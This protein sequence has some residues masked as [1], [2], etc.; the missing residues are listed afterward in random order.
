MRSDNLGRKSAVA[1]L[2][3]SIFVSIASCTKNTF[4]SQAQLAL[5]KKDFVSALDLCEKAKD[6]FPKD[7]RL[8]RCLKDAGGGIYLF[9]ANEIMKRTASY[10][11]GIQDEST[12]YDY[13]VKANRFTNAHLQESDD[14]SKAWADSFWHFTKRYWTDSEEL[15]T[16]LSREV[17]Q[18]ETET[19]DT[20]SRELQERALKLYLEYVNKQDLAFM[21]FLI[22]ERI[23]PTY[24]L[25]VCSTDRGLNCD[26]LR[27]EWETIYVPEISISSTSGPGDSDNQRINDEVVEDVVRRG[28]QSAGAIFLVGIKGVTDEEYGA[29]RRVLIEKYREYR[30]APGASAAICSSPDEPLGVTMRPL[31]RLSKNVDVAD[32]AELIYSH[33]RGVQCEELELEEEAERTTGRGG[34]PNRMSNRQ[35]NEFMADKLLKIYIDV[36]F[37]DTFV[38]TGFAINDRGY[39][40]TNFHV[41][42]RTVEIEIENK[43][44]D[45]CET[46]ARP[47]RIQ[48]RWLDQ[49]GSAQTAR[50][51][52]VGAWKE[53]DLAV[54]LIL[55]EGRLDAERRLSPLSLAVGEPEALLE[56][57]SYGYPEKASI[58]RR[59]GSLE[60]LTPT[61]T[62]GIVSRVVYRARRLGEPELTKV[63]HTAAITGGN[64]G[65]PLVDR[66][67]RVVGI[68]T[69]GFVLGIGEDGEATIVPSSINYASLSGDLTK[70]LERMDVD[71][72]ADGRRC[73]ER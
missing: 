3:L 12:A 58:D 71:F 45:D 2:L 50:A 29:M 46:L 66:C 23:Y 11:F 40:V 55:P 65:G 16:K 70:E 56:V 62:D 26:R 30:S 37:R 15:W 44:L 38:G 25:R 68:N 24:S 69:K 52:L 43:I 4:L 5:E 51:S 6:R 61:V 20:P 63:Q 8:E 14:L 28:A 54:L 21:H 27:K 19:G 9:K 31:R 10:N 35:I 39:V 60:S 72:I 49:D 47:T 13:L 34:E 42:C 48:V 59:E 64:S 17:E 1:V 33:T 53:M 18:M 41:I 36:K 67:G 73:P 7:Q 57:L 22:T 32:Y